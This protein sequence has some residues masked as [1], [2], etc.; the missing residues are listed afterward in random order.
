MQSSQWVDEN[1]LV[2]EKQALVGFTLLACPMRTWQ[3]HIVDH[4]QTTDQHFLPGK[5]KVWCGQSALYQCMMVSSL[6]IGSKY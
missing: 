4:L 1:P 2:L 3:Q 6:K 5:F